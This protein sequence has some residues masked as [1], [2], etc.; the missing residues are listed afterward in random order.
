GIKVEDI[1]LRAKD[2]ALEIR[3][4]DQGDLIR[5]MDFEPTWY[6][7]VAIERFE[8]A[9][10]RVLSFGELLGLG[11]TFE[12]TP[13][14]D[15]IIGTTVDDFILGNADDDVLQGGMGNDR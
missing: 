5:L 8:F 11:L 1:S 7:H 2:L 4:G 12:G 9:D 10:G 13:G 14:A 3:I 6:E 15:W